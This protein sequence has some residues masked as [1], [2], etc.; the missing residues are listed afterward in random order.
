[1]CDTSC[2]TDSLLLVF[3]EKKNSKAQP[4]DRLLCASRPLAEKKAPSRVQ[5][6]PRRQS[7]A[8]SFCLIYRR[9]LYSKIDF[10]SRAAYR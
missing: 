10:F 7:V 1:M 9:N 6:R 3:R 2:A 4:R 5:K 8:Q